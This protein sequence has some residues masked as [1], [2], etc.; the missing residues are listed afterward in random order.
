M[1]QGVINAKILKL[2]LIVQQD[3]LLITNLVFLNAKMIQ[4]VWHVVKMDVLNANK[5]IC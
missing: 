1:W 2:V 4:V 3:I 5:D